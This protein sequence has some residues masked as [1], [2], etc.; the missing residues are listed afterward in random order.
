LIPHVGLATWRL[1]TVFG[2]KFQNP[3]VVSPAQ[4]SCIYSRTPG[5]AGQKE[6]GD[7]Q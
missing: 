2:P 7:R 6:L 4:I 1:Y 5:H 3:P